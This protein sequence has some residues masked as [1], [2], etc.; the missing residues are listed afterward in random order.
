[1][2]YRK[3]GKTDLLVSVVGVGTWQYCGAWGKSFNLPEVK[4]ILTSTLA[5]GINM[6]DAAGC[7]GDHVSEKLVGKAIAGEREKW[8]IA[9][10]FGHAHRASGEKYCDFSAEGA[11]KQLEKQ[12]K[13]GKINHLGI[14]LHP[15][16][17]DNVWQ[18]EKAA[19]YGVEV[20]EVLYN[21]LERTAEDAVL[22]LC[23]ANG[24]GVIGRVPLCSGYLSGKYNRNSVF[25]SN[26]VRK[27]YH[28]KMDREEKLARA[29]I[30]KR[31]EVPKG[32]KMARWAMEWCLRNQTIN[33]VVGGF[34]TVAQLDD[35]VNTGN[36]GG[37][38][39]GN[40]R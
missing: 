12:K 9:T 18:T 17:Y 13:Q 34:K 33:T 2:E 39:A 11:K 38:Q 25:K 27:N 19:E 40:N 4:D 20:V 1:M 32:M 16:I 21:R 22:P 5:N 30:I 7:Y 23:E 29:E 37:V 3:V 28:D 14:S 35:A 26:D 31:Y 8:I 15:V 10:K 24:L 36:S 6:I